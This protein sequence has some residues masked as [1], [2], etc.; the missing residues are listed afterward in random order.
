MNPCIGYY[1]DLLNMFVLFHFLFLLRFL[2]NT[3]SVYPQSS[4]LRRIKNLTQT[5]FVLIAYLQLHALMLCSVYRFQ[6]TPEKEFKTTNTMLNVME[7]PD[8]F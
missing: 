7:N 5:A 8:F 6:N 1:V 2:S 3:N 4:L